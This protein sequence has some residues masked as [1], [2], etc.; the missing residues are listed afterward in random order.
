MNRP[1]GWIRLAACAAV[2]LAAQVAMAQQKTES[3]AQLQS[4]YS[5]SREVSVQGT[6]VS[7]AENSAEPG[8]GPR[9]A[10]QRVRG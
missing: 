1:I 7:F 8:I 6:V 4:S 5:A 9:V 2:V 3:V 10:L